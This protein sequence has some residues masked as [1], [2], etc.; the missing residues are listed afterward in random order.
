M[1]VFL[2][3]F[4]LRKHFEWDIHSLQMLFDLYKQQKICKKF[5]KKM[6][7]SLIITLVFESWHNNYCEQSRWS[8]QKSLRKPKATYVNLHYSFILITVDSE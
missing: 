6:S 7:P 2:L 4:L 5:F 8:H 1:P 3:S